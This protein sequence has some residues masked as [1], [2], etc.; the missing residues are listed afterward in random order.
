MVLSCGLG[1]MV[2]QCEEVWVAGFF[3]SQGD[4]MREE[5]ALSVYFFTEVT[6]FSSPPSIIC[7]PYTVQRAVRKGCAVG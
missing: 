1:L 2:P 6:G 5:V 7:F 4:L 3:F